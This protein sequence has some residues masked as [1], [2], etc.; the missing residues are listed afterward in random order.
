MIHKLGVLAVSISGSE[1]S[2]AITDSLSKAREHVAD[3][4]IDLI[5]DLPAP[6]SDTNPMNLE[7]DEPPT[8][9]GKAWL[10]VEPDGDV[11]PAQGIDKDLGNL[12]RD[13]WSDI[14]SRAQE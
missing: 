9:A 1:R 3:I 2:E 11:L 6:Y 8:G 14:W 12:L 7:L 5:W 4:D 13:K 10:Y